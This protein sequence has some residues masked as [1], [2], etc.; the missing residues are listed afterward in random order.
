MISHAATRCLQQTFAGLLRCRTKHAVGCASE[1]CFIVRTCTLDL[2]GVFKL[3]LANT[4]ELD[5][6]MGEDEYRDYVQS[7]S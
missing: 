5:G 3:K 6:L 1:S 7:I 4:A 2:Y